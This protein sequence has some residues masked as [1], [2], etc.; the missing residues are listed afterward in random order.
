MGPLAG[1]LAIIMQD[2]GLLGKLYAEG[3]EAVDKSPSR[4]LTAM[5]ANSLQKHRLVFLHNLF[6]RFGIKSLSA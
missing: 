6:L 1:V 4:G 2:V 3:H 5:G